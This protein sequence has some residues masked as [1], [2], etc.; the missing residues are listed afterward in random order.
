MRSQARLVREVVE[1]L[2]PTLLRV[3][4]VRSDVAMLESFAAQMF[5]GRGSWR[6][7]GVRRIM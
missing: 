7:G 4:A 2:G 5:A 6:P 1:P 3:R